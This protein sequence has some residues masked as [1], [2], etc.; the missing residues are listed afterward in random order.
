MDFY[1]G[2]QDEDVCWVTQRFGT[3]NSRKDVNVVA[4]PV[5]YILE[6]ITSGTWSILKCSMDAC[7]AYD[8]K[9][10]SKITRR[11]LVSWH[12]WIDS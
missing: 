9:V 11:F 6:E 10:A 5:P 12:K 3:G 8:S 2:V 1:Q 7:W 4:A